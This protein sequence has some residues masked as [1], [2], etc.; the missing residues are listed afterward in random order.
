[1]M[2]GDDFYLHTVPF[3]CLDTDNVEV[4]YCC[5]YDESDV[6]QLKYNVRRRRMR[7]E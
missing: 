5:I 7:I 6:L 3:G 4:G 2:S 1:M